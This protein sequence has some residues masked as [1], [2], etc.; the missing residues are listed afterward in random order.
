MCFVLACRTGLCVNWTTLELSQST[1]GVIWGT[2]SS[3][4]I[5]WIHRISAVTAD[6]LLYCA[7]VLDLETTFCFL[8]HQDIK[9]EPPYTAA[10]DLEC[11]SSGSEAQSDS[12]KPQMRRG[13]WGEAGY[14]ISPE[15]K[16]P[17]RYLKILFTVVQWDSRGEDMNWQTLLIEKLNS[18]WVIVTYWR[19]PTTDL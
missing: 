19:A 15:C 18:R 8:D 9:L 16:A 3:L 2:A 14:R 17:L 1:R 5:V 6:K 10:P 13:L 7:S 11:L 4:R 12:Q